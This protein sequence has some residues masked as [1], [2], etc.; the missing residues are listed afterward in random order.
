M[1]RRSPEPGRRCRLAGGNFP[2]GSTA[3]RRRVVRHLLAGCAACRAAMARRLAPP[4]EA[5]LD[6]V[7][8]RVVARSG[9]LVRRVA[10]ER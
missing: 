8:D 10:A 7:I 3:E 5:D 1:T 6:A 9:A 4:R 2:D